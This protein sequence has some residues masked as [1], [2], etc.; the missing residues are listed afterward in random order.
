MQS[1]R[2][3]QSIQ[4]HQPL[5]ILKEL[6]INSDNNDMTALDIAAVHGRIEVISWL[7]N[8]GVPIR[9]IDEKL[10]QQQ[11]LIAQFLTACSHHGVANPVMTESICFR[12][13]S[14][15]EKG[16]ADC[17]IPNLTHPQDYLA[18]SL[19]RKNT[20]AAQK[21]ITRTRE[22]K[23]ELK[24]THSSNLTPGFWAAVHELNILNDVHHDEEEWLLTLRQLSEEDQ[25]AVIDKTYRSAPKKAQKDL[26]DK[27]EEKIEEKM[28][29][30][31][32][33]MLKAAAVANNDALKKLNP[34]VENYYELFS[35]VYRK[36]NYV[37]I[38]TLF[39]CCDLEALLKM[40]LLNGKQEMSLF[41]II[42]SGLHLH[43]LALS[44]Q[45]DVCLPKF[46]S[47]GW[48]NENEFKQ[49]NQP[50]AI[51]KTIREWETAKTIAHLNHQIRLFSRFTN[52][53]DDEIKK[54]RCY[55]ERFDCNIWKKI[56][57]VAT[58]LILLPGIGSAIQLAYCPKESRCFNDYSASTGMFLGVSSVSIFF[59]LSAIL[60]DVCAQKKWNGR[61]I[62][63]GNEARFYELPVNHYND[64]VQQAATAIFAEFAEANSNPFATRTLDSKVSDVLPTIK[65]LLE[66]KQT[67]L[68]PLQV[69]P[70]VKIELIPMDLEVKIEKK[71]NSILVEEDDLADLFKPS[72]YS[73]ASFFQNDSNKPLLETTERKREHKRAFS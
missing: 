9:S 65:Q 54:T 66:E 36:K 58:F 45:K 12:A 59:L 63:V 23:Q 34:N 73:Y 42:G 56:W 68:E 26:F 71:A 6:K 15:E 55:Q 10:T 30:S 21:L 2:L 22:Q 53:L 1:N 41:L 27:D 24:Y 20:E 61:L 14:Q 13:L 32:K 57:V 52:A 47:L 38:Q 33:K 49:F 50:L 39:G 31:F 8:E 69:I 16:L 3:Q 37:A 35:Y 72:S 18:L 44:F 51:Y 25:H 48:E 46:I 4:S 67:A 29:E 62:K 64:Q 5:S 17:V 60:E 70:D 7:L 40:L 11:P 43:H 28:S 19:E